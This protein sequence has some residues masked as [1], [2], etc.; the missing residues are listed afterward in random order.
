M[1]AKDDKFGVIFTIYQTKKSPMFRSSLL[2]VTRKVG[3]FTKQSSRKI[4]SE[5]R[6]KIRLNKYV[7][8]IDNIIGKMGPGS[9]VIGLGFLGYFYW[10]VA[11]V[12]DENGVNR[13]QV[14]NEIPRQWYHKYLPDRK[15]LNTK[16]SG[17]RET[18]VK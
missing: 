11:M 8:I 13:I 18:D 15:N 14:F 7:Q 9:A 6:E 12:Y 5:T 4:S 3:S 1:E 10:Y 2:R 16:F 17:H